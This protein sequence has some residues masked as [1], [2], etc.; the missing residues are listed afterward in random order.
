MTA[1]YIFKQVEACCS[2]QCRKLK[3]KL[4]QVIQSKPSQQTLSLVEQRSSEVTRELASHGDV[5]GGWSRFPA[6]Q[7]RTI[8]P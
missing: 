5:L 2:E 1:T 6:P 7:E 3:R 4:G 8:D